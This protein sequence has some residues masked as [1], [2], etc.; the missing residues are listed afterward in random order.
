MQVD[1]TLMN[2]HLEFV[3]GLG[4]LSAR[5]YSDNVSNGDMEPMI[6]LHEQFCES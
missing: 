5:L 6:G 4:T 2:L 3:P 1:K